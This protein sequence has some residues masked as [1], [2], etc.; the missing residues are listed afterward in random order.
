[1]HV[2][3]VEPDVI[4]SRLYSDAFE[5][6]GLTVSC[7]RNAQSAIF[8]ADEKHPDVVVLELQLAAH[9]G[10]AFLYEFRSYGDWTETPIIIH[11][12]IPPDSLQIFNRTF[13]ELGISE[14]LYKPATSLRKLVSTVQKCATIN[15]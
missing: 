1:M 8:V 3:I 7:A 6:L 2:L 10:A 4:L 12:L 14:V 5:R 15:A 13:V 11:T 9:S